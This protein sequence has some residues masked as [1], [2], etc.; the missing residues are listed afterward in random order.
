MLR[1]DEG[2]M[3]EITLAKTTKAA[4]EGQRHVVLLAPKKRLAAGLWKTVLGD[5]WPGV[6]AMVE[7]TDP[8]ALGACATTWT[9]NGK[10]ER[11]TI[12]ALPDAVSRHASPSRHHAVQECV[13]R[14]DVR[15][16]GAAIV[17]ALDDPTHFLPVAVAIGR[18]FPLYRKKTGKKPAGRV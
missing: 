12:G 16:P 17:V 18:A 13:Q 15:G 1:R 5:D 11:L 4:L 3:A 8:G 7:H 6:A 10:P 14:A 2:A 9:G